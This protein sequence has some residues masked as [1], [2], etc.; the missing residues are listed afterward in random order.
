MGA[1]K[2]VGNGVFL[3][4]TF[5]LSDALKTTTAAFTP[6]C[7]N[8]SNASD[9]TV[10][11]IEEES[12]DNIYAIGILQEGVSAGSIAGRVRMMGISKAYAAGAIAAGAL[13]TAQNSSLG[14][15]DIGGTVVT[16]DFANAGGAT[17][18]SAPLMCLGRALEAAAATGDAL[19]IFVNPFLTYATA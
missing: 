17:A 16:L 4:V 10:H 6:V 14:T 1:L 11:G 18:L 5:N 2:N 13:L 3:D 9:N 12:T 19:Q 8:P 7:L 15:A